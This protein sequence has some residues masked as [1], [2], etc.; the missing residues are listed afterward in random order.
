MS[1]ARE[2]ACHGP[3]AAKSH[4]V[5]DTALT[6]ES[7]QIDSGVVHHCWSVDSGLPEEVW[8]QPRYR[9]EQLAAA[10]LVCTDHGL[11]VLQVTQHLQ[12]GTPAVG[13]SSAHV[14]VQPSY[15]DIKLCVARA[16]CLHLDL[17]HWK[18]PSDVRPAII[19]RSDSKESNGGRPEESQ[20]SL[21]DVVTNLPK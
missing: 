6:V 11:T 12:E 13:F 1:D 2:I 3:P 10:L 19:L 4:V 8:S 14:A 21:P 20:D 7:G 17:V 18:Q 9:R 16:R 5:V 15:R